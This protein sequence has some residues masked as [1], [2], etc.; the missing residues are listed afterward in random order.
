VGVLNPQ[1]LKNLMPFISDAEVKDRLG[2]DSNLANRNR[3]PSSGTPT[4]L[5]KVE[6]REITDVEER[7][8]TRALTTE[9]AEDCSKIVPIHNGG[10]RPGDKNIPDF[11]RS[12]IGVSAHL[13][14]LENTAEAFGVSKHHAFELK[15]GMHS[16][17]QGQDKELVESVN[18]Q[19][20]TPHDIAL[21]KLTAT[22]LKID[23]NLIT[24]QKDLASVAGTLARVADSTAPIKREDEDKS[25]K[26]VV[27]APS[28][29]QENHYETVDASK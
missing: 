5:P 11:M 20:K 8:D 26:L 29:K 12:V 9:Y 28:I 27:Y 19:L 3:I 15:H 1:T 2:K 10:R 21:S 14:T 16:T 13:D 4:P 23:P 6:R 22:L 18:E 25:F 17:A 7:K 24:K